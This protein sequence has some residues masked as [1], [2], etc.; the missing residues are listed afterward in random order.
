MKPPVTSF[1]AQRAVLDGKSSE[2]TGTDGTG[3][4]AGDSIT[5]DAPGVVREQ[6]RAEFP[7]RAADVVP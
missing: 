2:D 3:D 6:V 7:R 4:D 1:T 5:A